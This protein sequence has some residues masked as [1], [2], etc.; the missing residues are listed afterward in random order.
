MNDLLIPP[1]LNPS[2]PTQSNKKKPTDMRHLLYLSLFSI[3]V[4]TACDNDFDSENDTTPN[5]SAMY[6][7]TSET[8]TVQIDSDITYAKGLAYTMK[9]NL[10]EMDLELDMYY[11]D[12]T[13]EAR[14]LFM[15]IHGGGFTGGSKTSADIVDMAKYYAARGW[16]FASINYRTTEHLGSFSGLSETEVLE[17]FTGIAPQEWMQHAQ[18]NVEKPSD[19]MKSTAMYA[20]QRDSKAALRWLVANSD[21]YGIDT[22]YITVGGNSAG[23]VATIA[24]GISDQDDFRD[25]ITSDDDPTLVTTNLTETY[26]V[27]SMVYFWGGTSK[28]DLFQAVYGVYPYDSSDPELFMAHGTDDATVGTEYTEATELQAT[29]NDIGV[30]SKLITLQDEEHGAWDAEVDGKG[31]FELSFDFL[32]ERQGLVVD[33]D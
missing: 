22:N 9:N 31:L 32:V 3:L 17:T 27:R 30:Y 5:N 14:P 2:H 8:Y 25:E 29:Y 13:S 26:N 4:F 23:A 28:L 18:E 1:K 21:M 7:N 11:P 16:V 6:L 12:N 10:F 33:L 24:L 15:F 20:A 19:F